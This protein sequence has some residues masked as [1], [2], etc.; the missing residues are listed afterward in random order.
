MDDE[1]VKRAFGSVLAEEREAHG[2]SQEKLSLDSDV[3]RSYLSEI[4]QG[5][6]SPTLV[7]L[8]KICRT[9]GVAPSVLIA[10]TEQFL[11]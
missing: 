6:S 2:Y 11:G 4:E 5:Y 10:K 9:L 7:M 8:W 3:D 1:R